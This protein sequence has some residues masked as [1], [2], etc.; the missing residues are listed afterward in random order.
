MAIRFYDTALADKFQGWLKDKTIRILKPDEVDRLLAIKASETNDKPLRLPFIALSRDTSVSI[1]RNMR[2][3]MS[4]DGLML[5]SDGKKTVQ[6]N[7]IPI[8]LN[9]QLDIYT[10]RFDEG[11]EYLREFVFKM[12]NNPGFEVEI[13]YNDAKLVHKATI[14]MDSTLEDTSNIPQRLYAGEFTRWTIRFTVDDAY[15]F[16][17]PIVNNVS[18]D[19]ATDVELEVAQN[20]VREF[21]FEKQ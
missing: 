10:R 5:T 8:E 19:P 20:F 12:I 11:D 16:S 13:P 14:V 4:F 1:S 7:A 9:Y 2:T 17:V 3:P 21:D 18:I 15:F 6:L